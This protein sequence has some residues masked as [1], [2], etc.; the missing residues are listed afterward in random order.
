MSFTN[1]SKPTTAIVNST[2]VSIGTSWATVET[3][4]A[5]ETHTWATISQL[6]TNSDRPAA[7]GSSIALW[8]ALSFPWLSALPWQ[9]TGETGGITNQSK[10]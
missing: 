4:W 2:Q 9:T 1:Q 6:L 5:T 7:S 10:P 3:T 8:D